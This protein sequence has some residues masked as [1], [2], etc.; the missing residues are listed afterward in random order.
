VSARLHLL[1]SKNFSEGNQGNDN[2]IDVKNYN[3]HNNC[4]ILI[5]EIIL[6][7]D[8]FNKKLSEYIERTIELEGEKKLFESK[9]IEMN[10][11]SDNKIKEFQQR[12]KKLEEMNEAF[13]KKITEAVK[14]KAPHLMSVD[15]RASREDYLK[16]IDLFKLYNNELGKMNILMEE[17]L[18][19][20]IDKTKRYKQL[21]KSITTQSNTNTNT[22][23]NIN[24]PNTIPQIDPEKHKILA[25]KQINNLK[26]L[27]FTDKNKTEISYQN[28]FWVSSDM[29]NPNISMTLFGAYTTEND[30]NREVK[31][32]LSI[33]GELLLKLSKK[34]DDL[35][36]LKYEKEKLTKQI[37][38]NNNNNNNNYN[39]NPNLTNN[40]SISNNVKSKNPSID[41]NNYHSTPQMSA[42]TIPLDKY[43]KLLNNL[44]EEQEKL[45]QS[46][47]LIDKLKGENESL[48]NVIDQSKIK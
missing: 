36:K 39:T 40:T 13:G 3:T 46:T 23:L 42:Q 5:E 29:I 24:H 33:Q 10:S 16:T 2:Q 6:A 22:N 12:N 44:I 41:F 21:Y 45:R 38:G 18:T 20:A 19:K 27:L 1:T 8:N 4:N 32:L 14:E 31:D 30:L 43:E 28:T 25:D 17:K 15:L 11:T 47:M 34:E 26:W 9:L 35:S 37:N 7:V 48:K